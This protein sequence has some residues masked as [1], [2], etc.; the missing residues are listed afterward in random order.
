[1]YT[2]IDLENQPCF[3]DFLGTIQ[4]S[5]SNCS[6]R[7]LISRCRDCGDGGAEAEAS[8][9][10]GAIPRRGGAEVLTHSV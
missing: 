6:T 7:R 3:N 1:M 8:I 2:I 10:K 9:G 4:G 5:T